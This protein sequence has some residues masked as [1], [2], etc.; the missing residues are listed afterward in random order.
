MSAAIRPIFVLGSQRSGTTL[1]GNYVG[2]LSSVCHLGE[3]AGFW[4][5]H[6]VAEDSYK[7]M[8]TPYKERYIG[9]LKEHAA[10]FARRMAS[11]EGCLFYCDSTPWNLLI[12]EELA[13]RLPNAHFVLMLRHYSGVLQSLRRSYRDGYEA[14]GVTWEER[15]R[16]WSAFY[17]KASLIPHGRTTVVSYD[18]LCTRPA[19]TIVRLKRDLRAMGLDPQ[20]SDDRVFARSH[21]TNPAHARP[22]LAFESGGGRVAFRSIPSFDP[23]QWTGEIDELVAPL[24]GDVDRLLGRLY[25][26]V[27]TTPPGWTCGV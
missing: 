15:A 6:I 24:V 20:G 18:R 23:E 3:F 5:S 9:E 26:H 10:A 2:G 19:E 22:T 14:S 27:Y 8:P 12:V 16:Q 1:I 13:C 7:L 25:P 11:E 4:F 17:G 21:A